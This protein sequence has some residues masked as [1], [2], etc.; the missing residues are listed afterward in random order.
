VLDP[1]ILCFFEKTDDIKVANGLISSTSL[2][3]IYDS[4]MQG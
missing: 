1:E 4:V 3:M 2:V